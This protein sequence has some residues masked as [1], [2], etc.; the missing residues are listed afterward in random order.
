MINVERTIKESGMSAYKVAQETGISATQIW[1][2]TSGKQTPRRTSEAFLK[3]YFKK[4]KIK[5]YD[6]NNHENDE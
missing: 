2:W 5:V 6:L 1:R 4:K 3:A